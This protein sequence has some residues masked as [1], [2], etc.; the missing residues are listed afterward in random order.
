MVLEMA[1]ETLA[2]MTVVVTE[3]E[4]LAIEDHHLLEGGVVHLLG[5][6][7]DLRQG[8][9]LVEMMI[10]DHQG[11]LLNAMVEVQVLGE[12]GE[13]PLEGVLLHVEV[14]HLVVMAVI[15]SLHVVMMD[16]PDVM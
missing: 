7:E 5:E 16:L 4:D 14:L 10:V 3:G 11:D 12:E 9:T 8:E 2:E 13:A 6:E 1:H 15:V